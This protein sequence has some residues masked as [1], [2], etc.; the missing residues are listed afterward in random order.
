MQEIISVRVYT[1]QA[2]V[3]CSHSATHPYKNLPQ[4]D[5]T[6]TALLQLGPTAES[7]GQY[8]VT[9]TPVVKSVLPG[10]T[11]AL[12]CK[13]SSAVHSVSNG[14]HLAW[15]QQKPGESP[16]LLIYATST[17]QSGIPTRFSGSGSG[18]DFTLTISGVQAEDAGDYYC[19][20]LHY[21]SSS[22]VFTQCDTPVQKPP[23]AGLHSDC[24]AAAGTYCRV[25]KADSSA[26]SQSLRHTENMAS[27]G[28]LLCTLALC[29]HESSGQI[30]LTQ[31]PT[32]ESVSIG[33]SVT[34]NCRSS[35][36]G[37]TSSLAWYLQKP[38]GAPKLLFSSL[39][40]QVS[41]APA[42]FTDSR[43]RTNFMLT[44]SGVQA[45]Q[46]TVYCDSDSSSEISS[47]RSKTSTAVYTYSNYHL[48]AWYQQKPGEAPK[49]LIYAASTLQSGIPT[50]FS[51][52]G[53]GTDFTLTISEVQ[54]EDAGDYYCQS[55]H[56]GY[57]FTRCYTPVQKPPSAGLHSDCTAAAGTYCSC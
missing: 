10:D 48:L 39:N 19:Q 1:T 37:F 52:S 44:I 17:L 24:T 5:C 14:N 45:I 9:Q 53:S 57:V 18:T 21:P 56:S 8:T 32:V 2:V 20:S 25:F 33:G 16:K 28:L 30:V 43:S 7:S 23:S 42:P 22:W 4:L 36:S 26:L 40:S 13:V 15:Y 49:L 31:S 38:G 55:Y 6:A 29:A 27:L 34:L 3:L 35:S 54:A 47:P 41:G 12:S 11:V 50:R 46:W 51:G